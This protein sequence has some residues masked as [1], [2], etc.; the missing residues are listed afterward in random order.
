VPGPAQLFHGVQVPLGAEQ[1]GG[2]GQVPPA[3]EPSVYAV[4]ASGGPGGPG[5][6]VACPGH[7]HDALHFHGGLPRLLLVLRVSEARRQAS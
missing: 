2:V 5:G 4:R 3:G 1:R 7:D 6:R